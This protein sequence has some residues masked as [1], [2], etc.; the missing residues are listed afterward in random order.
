MV[1]EQTVHVERC[2][3][4]CRTKN[5]AQDLVVVGK[6]VWKVVGRLKRVHVLQKSS[7]VVQ[8]RHVEELLVVVVWCV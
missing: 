6:D 8:S 7:V 1:V 2:G 4:V 5:V 3:Y